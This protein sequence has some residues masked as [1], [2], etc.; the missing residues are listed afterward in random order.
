MPFATRWREDFFPDLSALP[1]FSAQM[2]TNTGL[3][4]RLTS[5]SQSEINARIQTGHHPYIAFMEKT[6]V[7]YGWVA[8]RE[9]SISGFQFFFTI[10]AKNCY[11]WNF[12]TL[13]EWRGR[14]I[15]PHFL[16][17]IIHQ[18]RLAN[19]FWIGYEPGNEASA[20]GISKAGFHV[21]SELI[22]VAGS[23]SGLALFD[24]SKYA[25]ASA[26]FFNLPIILEK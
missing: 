15:Y 24:S 23:V 11:L 20:R 1:T 18:E 22:I 25:Q 13:P 6:P 7:A 5:L 2:S 12:L 3:I 16:Q 19:H 10:P 8:T 17:A 4:A 26:S 21:V 14:G 9:A